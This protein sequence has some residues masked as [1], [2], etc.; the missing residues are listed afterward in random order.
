MSQSIANSRSAGEAVPRPN[1]LDRAFRKGV[2]SRLASLSDGRLTLREPDG[3]VHVFGPGGDL[4]ATI[5]IHSPAFW[6]AVATGGSIGAADAWCDGLWTTADLVPL[7]RLFVR[8]RSTLVGVEGGVA[9]L[10][11]LL[12]RAAHLGRANSRSGSRKNIS[13]HYDLGNDFFSLFL[14]PTLSYSSAIYPE[15]TSGLEAAAL[16]KLATVVRKLDLRRE[17]HLLEIGTGW[18]GLAI[19]AARETGC[20]VTT[21][22]ISRRQ[23]ELA[24]E[25]IAAAGLSDRIA[26]VEVDYRDLSGTFDRLVS[27]E[28]IEA[29]GHENFDA[30]FGKCASLLADDGLFVLQGITLA[31]RYYDD[32]LRSADF[33]QRRVFPGSVLPSV[34]A[35]AA[36]VAR[37]T[38]LT[39]S[40]IEEIGPH[41]ARTLADWRSRFHANL[42]RVRELGY[43]EGFIRLWDYYLAYCE[44]G[45]REGVVG[46]VQVV[47]DKPGRRIER[48]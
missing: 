25:R 23:A 35:I 19:F 27:I 15:R 33:I 21:T 45:Y 12:A 29:V 36:S 41:Y 46:D 24:P 31:D 16:H 3:S 32:Y 26:V 1:F 48:G 40:N 9:R 5:E 30:Y 4:S 2:L 42:D 7:M 13:E 20:R 34:G 38:D 18:G 10:G 37:A 47:L 17:H 28:M 8:N 43:D 14:D 6:R 11:N 39:I 22:T 44:G